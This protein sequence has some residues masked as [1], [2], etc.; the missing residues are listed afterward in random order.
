M[1]DVHNNSAL[2]F[3]KSNNT[4]GHVPMTENI[5]SLSW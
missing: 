3:L 1:R 2:A 5:R 4:V